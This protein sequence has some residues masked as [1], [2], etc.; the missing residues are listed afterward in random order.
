MSLHTNALRR[1][2]TMGAASLIAVAALTLTACQGES[3]D[4]ASHSDSVAS[5]SSPSS[6]PSSPSSA[7]S[8]ADG[9]GGSGGSQD[10]SGAKQDGSAATKDSSPSVRSA[11]DRCTAENMSLRLG[12][13]DVGAGSI[14]YPLVFTNQSDRSCSLVGFPGVSLRRGDGQ[15]IGSPATREGSAT[16]AV[17]LAPGQSAHAVLHTI[18]DGLRDKPCWATATIVETYPPGS[19]DS[20]TTR[21]PG[22]RVCGGEFTVTSMVPGTQV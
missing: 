18:N 13:S 9:D 15:S 5:S 10:S 20:M 16:K 17:S 4:A 19:K 14:R 11:S 22:L 12:H 8:E 2:R 21:S 3:D 1:G 6:P 7:V